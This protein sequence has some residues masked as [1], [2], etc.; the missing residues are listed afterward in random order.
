MR[1]DGRYLTGNPF[2]VR[3][4]EEVRRE[5]VNQYQRE[6]NPSVFDELRSQQLEGIR[7]GRL[8]EIAVYLYF[9]RLNGV[10]FRKANGTA[11]DGNREGQTVWSEVYL[12]IDEIEE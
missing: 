1:G 12:R 9:R 11:W 7:A 6:F 3:Y 8:L 10:P 2:V 4:P 5:Y